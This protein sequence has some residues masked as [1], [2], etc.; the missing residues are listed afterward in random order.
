MRV[1]LAVRTVALLAAAVGAGVGCGGSTE[2][3]TRESWVAD[4]VTAG[5]VLSMTFPTASASFTGTGSLS[6]LLVPGSEALTLS[7]AR[8]ADTLDIVF[9][10]TTGGQFR[11]IGRYVG[12][13]IGISGTLN[14]SEF[15][16]TSASFRKQ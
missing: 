13:G 7:G 11:F 6:T 10:R 1:S 4:L 16:N 15:T 12:G 5:R 9:N 3:N 2:P 8:R 14:G